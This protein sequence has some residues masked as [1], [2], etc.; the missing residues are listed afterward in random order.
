MVKQGIK[1]YIETSVISGYGRKRFHYPLMRF[2][3]LLKEG[4]FI[5]IISLHTLKELYNE[6]TPIEVIQNLKTIEYKEYETTDEMYSLADKYMEKKIVDK[7]YYSDAL[8]IAI[9]TVLGVDVLVSWNLTHIVNNITKSLF[10][11]VNIN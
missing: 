9:T 8:H 10:N 6:K 3:D 5:P 4:V 1:V 7:Q 11:K 2:F